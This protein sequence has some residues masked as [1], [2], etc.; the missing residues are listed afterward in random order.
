M[1]V[2]DGP[3]E[4]IAL[5]IP[6]C[7]AAASFERDYQEVA[8][9]VGTVPWES[10]L[11]PRAGRFGWRLGQVVKRGID[12]VVAVLLGIVVAPLLVVLGALTVLDSGWPVFYPWR[13]LGH[14][15]RRFTGYKIRTMVP[16]ADRMKAQYNHLNEMSGPVFKIRND[17]RVTRVGRLLRKYSLDEL[18]QLWSVLIGDMSLVGP[19][20]PSPGEFLQYA[21]W[22]RLKLAVRPGVTCLWQVSGRNKISSFDDWARLDLAYIGDWSL[23]LDVA[24]LARTLPAVLRGDGAY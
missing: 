4:G 22:Q 1:S 21:E 7:D 14:R 19:R 5:S 2:A 18:P 8:R 10:A 24:I 12:I 16:D 17:P 20:P 11:P 3:A 15:G 6:A 23:W 13:V 9:I